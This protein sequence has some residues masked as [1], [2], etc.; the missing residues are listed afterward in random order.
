LKPLG[1]WNHVEAEVINNVATITVNRKEILKQDLNDL[2]RRNPSRVDLTRQSGRISL[3]SW[4]SEVRFRNIEIQ[5]LS[6]QKK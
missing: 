6:K 5:D 1:Q 3:Q 2:A 4:I